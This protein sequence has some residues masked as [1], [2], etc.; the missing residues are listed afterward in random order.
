MKYYKQAL[1]SLT[2][3]LLS[4]N[5]IASY[6]QSSGTHTITDNPYIS[7][8]YLQI[9]GNADVTFQ[10]DTTFNGISVSG[11]GRV[12]SITSNTANLTVLGSLTL[13]G[14]FALDSTGTHTFNG[15]V[16]GNFISTGNMKAFFRDNVNLTQLSS[17]FN[18][19]QLT[20]DSDVVISNLLYNAHN[21]F[22]IFNKT[23]K[24]KTFTA[25]ASGQ[26]TFND[27]VTI[28]NDAT[29][30][31][32]YN[33]TFNK[34]LS[35]GTSLTISDNSNFSII[36]NIINSNAADITIQNTGTAFFGGDIS[37]VNL[38]ISNPNAQFNGN[39]KLTGELLI[40]PNITPTFNGQIEADTMVVDGNS[41]F[42]FNN[43]KVGTL[44]IS[45]TSSVNFSGNIESNIII[46]PGSS[47]TLNFAPGSS[48]TGHGI[49]IPAGDG[50][51]AANPIFEGNIS[52]DYIDFD[53]SISVLTFKNITL[54]SPVFFGARF[55]GIG[56][57]IGGGGGF[58]IAGPPP[59][60]IGD[61]GAEGPIAFNFGDLKFIDD[62][63]I[64]KDLGSTGAWLNS[65]EFESSTINQASTVNLESNIYSNNIKFNSP[66]NLN[67]INDLKI[68][69]GQNS[70]NINNGGTVQLGTNRL[71][72]VG[73][74]NL[75]GDIIFKTSFDAAANKGGNILVDGA[76]SIFDFSKANSVKIVLSGANSIPT[77]GTQYQFKLFDTANGGTINPFAG[78]IPIEINDNVFIDWVWSYQ[79]GQYTLTATPANP[80][81]VV[82]NLGGTNQQQ[83]AANQLSAA[84]LDVLS[85]IG[86]SPDVLA[87]INNFIQNEGG[88]D[89]NASNSITRHTT[90]S[91]HQTNQSTPSNLYTSYNDDVELLTGVTAGDIMNKYGFW[92]SPFYST[93]LEKYQNNNIAQ[94]D[95]SI[96]FGISFGAD[97]LIS[98]N[99]MVGLGF[100][101]IDSKHKGGSGNNDI[102][103]SNTMLGSFYFHH[104]IDH[105]YFFDILLGGGN[106]KITS[107]EVRPT[108]NPNVHLNAIGKYDVPSL[109]A[110]LFLG[111]NYKIN[112]KMVIQPIIGLGSHWFGSTK[113]QETGA[114]NANLNVK[115]GVGYLFESTVGARLH[116]LT[117][118]NGIWVTPEIHSY[119]HYDFKRKKSKI[120]A[121]LPGLSQPLPNNN[122]K[123][124]KFF[125]QIGTDINIQPPTQNYELIL[126]YE[127]EFSKKYHA[128]TMALK[129]KLFF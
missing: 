95:S 109:N 38:A 73:N 31:Q 84:S 65:L 104:E 10:G 41:K 75:L 112:K 86:L 11:P 20:F 125:A 50:G 115:K 120:S 3:I 77:P 64:K 122:N 93:S 13:A 53:P 16:N 94:K 98:E 108:S 1:T 56:I 39:I 76:N 14:D 29:I 51:A 129:I 89:N 74:S 62:S 22:S 103:K 9:S 34:N 96:L 116:Y 52:F 5:T 121:T 49:I 19:G 119:L 18:S 72:C 12:I 82:A 126:N 40:A 57:G 123:T 59:I 15:P 60:E 128:Q 124:N 110:S 99:S 66:V 28:E 85:G 32:N 91:F 30:Y 118:I 88:V 2:T 71:T 117:S 26:A 44:L 35:I 7:S 58:P 114:G 23:V 81:A 67:I 33:A 92:F 46:P 36:G 27:N 78:N 24:T 6:I 97:S 90:N 25:F 102:V 105:K 43:L 111:Y 69:T 127:L 47:P 48:G 54:N 100:T 37:A 79:T 106:H 4:H 68:S 55:G 45:G 21:G 87:G 70:L 63:I 107:R 8:G 42:T 61:G 83:Q 101:I 113:Y 80:Q 17:Y